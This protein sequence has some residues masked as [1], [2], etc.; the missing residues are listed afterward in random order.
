MWEGYR[1]CGIGDAR[2]GFG[3]CRHGGWC[4]LRE[5]DGVLGGDVRSD[6][7]ARD[8]VLGGVLVLLVGIATS[9]GADWGSPRLQVSAHWLIMGGAHVALAVL[10][11]AA[12]RAPG[13]PRSVSRVWAAMV[14]AGCCYA[15]GDGV[16]LGLLVSGRF[17]DV[18][19]FGGHAQSVLILV[20]SVILVGALLLTPAGWTQR[21]R[22]I[23]YWLDV[24][25][26]LVAGTAFGGYAFVAGPAG[27]VTFAL[28]LL[29]GP[30]IYLVGGFAIVRAALAEV[31]PMTLAAGLTVGAAATLE[32]ALQ[33]T[34]R[35]LVEHGPLSW[36]LGLTQIA[37]I[38]LVAGAR[39][40]QLQNVR[41][42]LVSR[43]PDASPSSPRERFTVLPYLAIAVTNLL[44]VAVLAGR[45]LDGHVWVVILGA[46]LSTGLV[47]ARQV[48]A[49]ADNQHLVT[50]LDS[51]VSQLRQMMRERDELTAQL[52]H[53]A[54]HDVLTG[55]PNRAMFTDRLQA[56]CEEP[57]TGPVAVMLVDLDDF[58]PVND[59]YGHSVGDQVLVEA[60]A[61]MQ[62]CVGP[63]GLVAR[64]GG[65]EFG[66]LLQRPGD[67][68]DEL[69]RRVLVAVSRPY[70]VA[71]AASI[72]ASIGVAE[73]HQPAD[74]RHL[75]TGADEAMYA[76]KHSTKGT[77]RITRERR[78]GDGVP[79]PAPGHGSSPGSPTQGAPRPRP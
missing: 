2:P 47:V 20:G 49:S 30:G 3:V 16:Q 45:G 69:A 57:G 75:I 28:A 6:G 11:A 18:V 43:H 74:P 60:A 70:P 27:P 56:L 53:K 25:I 72:S 79:C 54:Y 46:T 24:V 5:G 13:L 1:T 77:Y 26:V 58:K 61:R 19:V 65:D 22:R 55:L 35:L 78:T 29:T 44:L 23:Q 40:Q 17:D 51:T 59:S 66:I 33:A 63:D 62:R 42:R 31:P 41:Y 32:A 4:L 12:C 34:L 8:P 9:F 50:V 21:R 10:A 7:L 68:V 38:L 14:I 15:A 67:D 37:S 76:A 52:H 64:I 39:I 73:A 36:F 48:L 71:A